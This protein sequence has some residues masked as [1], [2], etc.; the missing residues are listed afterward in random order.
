M[1]LRI[2]DTLTTPASRDRSSLL[3][4]VNFLPA[5]RGDCS[6]FSS[7]VAN[8]DIVTLSGHCGPR[9]EGFLEGWRLR[10]GVTCSTGQCRRECHC[11]AAVIEA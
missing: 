2:G 9:I 4:M 5:G 11:R 7:F 10:T 3:T 1:L 6:T 8:E